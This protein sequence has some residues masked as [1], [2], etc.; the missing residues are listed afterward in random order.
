MR[1]LARFVYWLTGKLPLPECIEWPL[2]EWAY[3]TINGGPTLPVHHIKF[4]P[5]Q[6]ER[7]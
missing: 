7:E 5:Q 1:A 4:G 2:S 3:R 6:I